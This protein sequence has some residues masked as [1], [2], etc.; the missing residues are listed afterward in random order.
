ME[1]QP[2]HPDMG[3]FRNLDCVMETSD[4]NTSK[5]E[6]TT[7]YVLTS[8]DVAFFGQI[9]KA[10]TEITVEEITNALE[11]V[12]DHTIFPP[13]LETTKLMVAPD[14]TESE[15]YIKRP[16]LSVY[17]LFKD[18]DFLAR[19]LLSEAVTM[20]EIAQH[21]H[22]NIARYH[23]VRLR[24]GRITGLVLDNYP[25]TL[26][27]HVKRGLSLDWK[28][29]M[30]SL[31]SAVA[32]L[33]SLGLA[34]NDINPENI[35]VTADNVLILMDFGSCGPFGKRVP[36]QGTP[37]WTDKIDGR[38]GKEHDVFGLDKI[39]KW[40]QAECTKENVP[41]DGEHS[42]S[43]GTATA[44]YMDSTESGTDLSSPSSNQYNTQSDFLADANTRDF[45]KG[46]AESRLVLPPLT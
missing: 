42:G 5:I 38:S 27:E 24:R 13:M 34:H 41:D 28:K 45:Q 6:Y 1:E 11:Q 9:H 2:S 15:F 18:D 4:P 29:S 31:E 39:R 17:E 44:D 12:P 40:F 37:E 32:H 23:G 22:P 30:Q 46:R 35:M 3:L 7:F 19:L 43:S 25:C 10:K 21:P 26:L 33:H 8:N 16:N 20:Q 14:H 36:T